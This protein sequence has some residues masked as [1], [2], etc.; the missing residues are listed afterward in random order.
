MA[1]G[2]ACVKAGA[3]GAAK[4]L[5]GVARWWPHSHRC[6]GTSWCRRAR[7]GRADVTVLVQRASAHTRG[8]SGDV[9]QPCGGTPTRSCPSH[10]VT[11]ELQDPLGREAGRAFPLWAARPQIRNHWPLPRGSA[12]LCSLKARSPQRGAAGHAW[13]PLWL[14]DRFLQGCG[15][16]GG[17]WAP[18]RL[19][20]FVW[21]ASSHFPGPGWA[22]PLTG[23]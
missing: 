7:W 5:H 4:P 2:A 20:R 3:G 17:S 6:S 23:A 12:G 19:R 11:G 13:R 10:R 22:S 21:L 15:H 1:E 14:W 18:A 8:V 9:T 16:Q